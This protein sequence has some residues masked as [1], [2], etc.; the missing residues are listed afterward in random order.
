MAADFTGTVQAVL[1]HGHG[2]PAKIHVQRTTIEG[3]LHQYLIP[4][5]LPRL[6]EAHGP[7]GF[8]VA[9]AQATR[10]HEV[11]SRPGIKH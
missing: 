3:N 8:V 5:E 7:R 9:A 10:E 4:G 2:N 11:G 1:G 6:C